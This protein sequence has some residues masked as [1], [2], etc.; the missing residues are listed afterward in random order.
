M[1]LITVPPIT[2]RTTSSVDERARG[3]AIGTGTSPARAVQAL[4]RHGQELAEEEAASREADVRGEPSEWMWEI[5][6]VRVAAGHA[7]DDETAWLA[8]G[9]VRPRTTNPYPV[10]DRDLLRSER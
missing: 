5:I 3:I 7:G 2:L 4:T 8:T 6:D 9:T 10:K 1:A